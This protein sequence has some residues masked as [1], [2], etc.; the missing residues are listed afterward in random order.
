MFWLLWFLSILLYSEFA[1]SS[2]QAG[3]PGD[4]ALGNRVLQQFRSAGLVT[5]T[6]EHFVTLQQLPEGS[7]NR[8]AFKGKE[9]GTPPASWPTAARG[10][11]R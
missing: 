9:L 4:E 8:L 3:S 5:W 1:S 10:T 7:T 11:S 6:D 2:H